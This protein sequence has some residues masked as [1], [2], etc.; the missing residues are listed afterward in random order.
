M[1]TI[2]TYYKQNGVQTQVM[3]AS[4]RSTAQVLALA[5]SDLLTIAPNLLDQLSQDEQNVT[6]QLTVE[7]ALKA[8]KIERGNLDQTTF[9]N[10]LEH[11]L[12]AFQLLQGGV[13]G[14]IKARDQLHQVLRESYGLANIHA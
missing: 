9:Q 10:E 3:G 1:K 12:M 8:E 13:D 6:A 7:Q 11:D 4:F 2:Y 5:G 14:F